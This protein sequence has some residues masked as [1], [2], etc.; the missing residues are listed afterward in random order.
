[1]LTHLHAGEQL[2]QVGGDDVFERDEPAAYRPGSDSPLDDPQEPGQHRG[3]LDPGEVLGAGRRVDEDDGEV[4]RQ[5]GDVGERVGR[6]DGQRGEHREDLLAEEAVQRRA[7]PRAQLAQG[8]M[9]MPSSASAGRTW[10]Q[11]THECI[12]I[13]SCGGRLDPIEQFARLHAR[14]PSARPGRWRCAA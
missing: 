12:R 14:P 9:L 4:E 7:R 3:H 5:A 1:V 2:V 13:R 6:V 8:T 10:S 11:N